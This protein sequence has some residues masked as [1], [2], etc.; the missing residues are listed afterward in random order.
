V[1]SRTETAEIPVDMS[2]QYFKSAEFETTVTVLAKLD[3]SS[4]KFRKN[5]DRNNDILTVVSVVFDRNGN[6]IKGVQRTVDMKLRDQTLAKLIEQGG[7]SVRSTLDLEPGS[8]L[9]RLVVRDA[10]GK[11]MAARNGA[12]EIP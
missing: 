3:V 6:F 10:G 7:I 12:V 2:L 8:Y 4:L 11:T 1:F 5:D 9:V